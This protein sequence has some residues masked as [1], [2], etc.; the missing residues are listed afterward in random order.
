MPVEWGEPRPA[1]ILL[2]RTPPVISA[3]EV[4]F[5]SL[6]LRAAP[7]VPTRRGWEPVVE[8]LAQGMTDEAVGRFLALDARTVRRRVAEAMDELGATSRFGLG[9]AWGRRP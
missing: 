2:V 1:S 5:D 7:A 3:L 6:W 9:V 4:V 8:L